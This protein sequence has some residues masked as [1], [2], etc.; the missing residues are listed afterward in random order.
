[1]RRPRG[2]G[3]RFLTAEEIAAQKANQEA[4]AGP[5]GTASI[6]GEGEEDVDAIMDS[7][8][9]LQLAVDS[10]H[11]GGAGAGEGAGTDE[12]AGAGAEG[13]VGAAEAGDGAAAAG[14]RCRR[15]GW[16][17]GWY[18]RVSGRVGRTENIR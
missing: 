4:E 7:P 10:P 12:G 9:D 16:F 15:A 6:D 1:M 14:S 5:S 18:V 11:D 3:G 13:V 17:L 8:G 2:P